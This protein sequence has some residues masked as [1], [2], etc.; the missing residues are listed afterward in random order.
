MLRKCCVCLMIFMTGLISAQRD[1]REI[2]DAENIQSLRIETDEVYHIKLSTAETSSISIKTHSEGEYYNDIILETSIQDKQL[3]IF[4]KYPEILTGGYDK[5]SAHKVFSLEI[6]ISLPAELEIIINS[7][8]A[9]VVA[10]G[11]YKSVYA[12]L[13]QGYCHLLKFSG[14]AVINT[15]NGDILV[16]AGRGLIEASSRNGK[17]NIPEFLPGR[18]PLRLTSIDGDI[19]VRKN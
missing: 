2:I 5:L 11:D 19:L 18:R 17:V 9:S 13:K 10:V 3:K 15:Y 7:N 8:L 6:E 4:T 1:T 16:E 14:S 12:D